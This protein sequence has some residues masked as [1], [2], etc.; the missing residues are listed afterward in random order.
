MHKPLD[1][2]LLHKIGVVIYLILNAIG[3]IE[4][5]EVEVVLGLHGFLVQAENQ[6]LHLLDFS[7]GIG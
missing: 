4:G 5:F 2:V 1:V 6:L 7:D 3:T